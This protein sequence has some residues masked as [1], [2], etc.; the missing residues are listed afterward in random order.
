MAMKTTRAQTFPGSCNLQLSPLRRFTPPDS[1]SS[2]L[3]R[4][5]SRICLWG[6][7]TAPLP[8]RRRQPTP[9]R[10]APDDPDTQS[11]STGKLR[12]TL[13]RPSWIRRSMP[14]PGRRIGSQKV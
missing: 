3:G 4:V 1:S 8:S 13:P 14:P 7:L 12:S 11:F 6:S 5:R 2:P 10:R 9:L